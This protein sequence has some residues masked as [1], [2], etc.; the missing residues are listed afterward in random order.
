MKVIPENILKCMSPEDRRKAGQKT[1]A[2]VMAQG[3]AKSEK[4]LQ[5]A[6]VGLL[7]LKGI[8]PIVSRMDRRT[9]NNVGTPDIL[10]AVETKSEAEGI[11]G[12][13]LITIACAWEVKMPGKS[14]EPHQRKMSETLANSPNGWRVRVI[15]SI[16]EALALLREMGIE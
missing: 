5:R 16:D 1:A 9:S 4:E 10:F 3:E 11:A 12:G 7:R 6:I 13:F 8:E 15:H 2:E 14:L